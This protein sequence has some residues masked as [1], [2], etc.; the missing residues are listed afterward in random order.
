MMCVSRSLLYWVTGSVLEGHSEESRHEISTKPASD[1]VPNEFVLS[2]VTFH[3]N[4]WFA[5][6][7]LANLVDGNLT[8]KEMALSV[9]LLIEW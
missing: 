5:S 9:G 7:M 6:T 4:F 1:V 2:L 8:A 3:V